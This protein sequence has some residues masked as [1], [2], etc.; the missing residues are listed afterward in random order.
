MQATHRGLIGALLLLLWVNGLSTVLF[1][2]AWALALLGG[3]GLDFGQLYLLIA[4]TGT[5][6]S[7][8]GLL[9]GVG[10]LVKCMLQPFQFFLFSFYRLLPL[11][12]FLYYLTAYY[13]TLLIVLVRV[14]TTPLASLL[15][16]WGFGVLA[17]LP[18]ALVTLV[19]GL[20]GFVDVRITLAFST[21][22]NLTFLLLGVACVGNG[23]F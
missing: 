2:W 4:G 22:L 20:G 6:A 19:G 1:L 10:L 7:F 23:G 13:S 17:T 18:L 14:L 3:W 8:V 21:L 5:G 16:G 12:A 11:S 15:G 9:V